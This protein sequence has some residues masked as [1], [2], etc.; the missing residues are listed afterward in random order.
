M[1]NPLKSTA[2]K[3]NRSSY[4][5]IHNN[6]NNNHLHISNNS[7]NDHNAD[8]VSETGKVSF[9]HQNFEP[10]PL[11]SNIPKKISKTRQL[12]DSFY[13]M[14]FAL[15]LII[16]FM[17]LYFKSFTSNHSLSNNF[18]LFD[19]IENGTTAAIT[20]LSFATKETKSSSTT[21]TNSNNKP[22]IILIVADDLGKQIM[23][24][25]QPHS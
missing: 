4:G 16:V 12:R 10:L 18:I 21:T 1:S 5:S 9:Q 7:D 20:S 8:N 22:N 19:E 25:L 6:N 23:A 13:I 14:I 2:H 15:L 3:K 11:F 17:G 24:G